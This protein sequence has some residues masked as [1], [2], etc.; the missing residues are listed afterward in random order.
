MKRNAPK[1]GMVLLSKFITHQTSQPLMRVLRCVDLISDYDTMIVEQ[2]WNG[3]VFSG[4][5]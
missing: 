3:V 1:M 2:L 4:I 5:C